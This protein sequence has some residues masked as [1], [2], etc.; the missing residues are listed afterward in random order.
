MSEPERNDADVDA[1]LQQMH[2]RCVTDRMRR[3][4]PLCQCRLSFRRV[5]NSQCQPKRDIG[6]GHFAPIPIGQQGCFCRQI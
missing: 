1:C 6:A 4:F 3:D 5:L 2:C